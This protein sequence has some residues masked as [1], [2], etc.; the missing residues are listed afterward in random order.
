MIDYLNMDDR[1]T[2]MF[3]ALSY[4]SEPHACDTVISWLKLGG[5][6]LLSASHLQS[7]DRITMMREVVPVPV[8]LLSGLSLNMR[9]I[10]A[11]QLEETMFSGK[12]LCFFSSSFNMLIGFVP[13]K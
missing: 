11:S 5:T 3:W 6:E 1:S 10:L 13:I 4:V 2:G 8:S 9:V 12:V 7:S